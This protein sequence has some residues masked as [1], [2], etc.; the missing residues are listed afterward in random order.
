MITMMTYIFC[1]HLEIL[2][3]HKYY[4]FQIF[5]KFI[6]TFIISIKFILVNLILQSRI[7]LDIKL[8]FCLKNAFISIRI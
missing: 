1:I 6:Y 7:L 2:Y 5:Q 8:N 3:L 4:L